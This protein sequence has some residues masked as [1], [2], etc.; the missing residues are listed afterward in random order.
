MVRVVDVEAKR[1]HLL[2]AA[3]ACF[4]RS[5]YDGT[6]MNDVAAAAKVSKGSV[7]DYFKSKEDLFYGVFA[8]LQQQLMQSLLAEM[9]TSASAQERIVRSVDAAVAGLV[10]HISLY[11][12]SLE[13]WAAAARTQTRDRFAHAM[14]QTY[15]DY[16]REIVELVRSAQSAGE[17]KANV[18]AESL[19]MVL[20]GAVD[21]LMLQYW[22]DPSI[23]PHR[24]V[25][26]FFTALFEGIGQP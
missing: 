20:V 10:Q 9:G 4:A 23:D 22:L 1:S 13:V 5:G 17:L 25:R 2:E 16:R 14:Q 6:S 26:N 21:G 18:D 12:V 19:A 15:T 7:Y 3:A 24:V 11:P 8:W